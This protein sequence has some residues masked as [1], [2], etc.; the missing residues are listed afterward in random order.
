[1]ADQRESSQNVEGTVTTNLNPLAGSIL[2]TTV[3]IGTT[4]TA[5]PTSALTNRKSLIGYNVGT[6]TVFLG[7]AGVTTA[8]GIP[9]VGTS[10][11][12]A[13][14]LG[15]TVLYGIVVGTG[16]TINVMEVS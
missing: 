12:P 9:V 5:I 11:T 14:D 6:A 1:M 8:S 2:N 4:V 13:M 7:G 15:T 16:G 10:F 3:S